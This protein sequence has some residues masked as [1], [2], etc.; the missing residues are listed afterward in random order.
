MLAGAAD[1]AVTIKPI[2]GAAMPVSS[3]SSVKPSQTAA[4]TRIGATR[5]AS[6][7]AP[8][9]TSGAAMRPSAVSSNARLSI[10]SLYNNK[11]TGMGGGSA[12]VKPGPGGD[13]SA[14]ALQ[15]DVDSMVEALQLRIDNTNS[16]LD[17]AEKRLDQ[18]I[19]D[20]STDIDNLVLGNGGTP[21]GMGPQGEKGDK[22]DTG[23]QGAPGLSAYQIAVQQGFIGTED[24]WLASLR[25]GFP[26]PT[27]GDGTYIIEVE[28]GGTALLP[29]EIVTGEY[30]E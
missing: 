30:R 23:P 8:V 22:G 10:G 3:A 6:V 18:R 5:V 7:K 27:A 25:G 17:T 26:T 12:T 21:G 13:M 9:S 1:A 24:Q 29:V 14:Y 19:D 4:P 28:N 2:G 16:A 20:L 15:R 11:V